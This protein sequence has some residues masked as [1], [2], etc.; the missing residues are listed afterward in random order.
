M[1]HAYAPAATLGFPQWPAPSAVA[2]E[3]SL[4]TGTVLPKCQHSSRQDVWLTRARH[5]CRTCELFLGVNC[6]TAVC[7]LIMQPWLAYTAKLYALENR[8]HGGQP[9]Q[10]CYCCKIQ[11]GPPRRRG[12]GCREANPQAE[13]RY[14]TGSSPRTPFRLILLRCA[15][16]CIAVTGVPSADRC[17]ICF[18]LRMQMCLKAFTSV[19]LVVINVA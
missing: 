3:A 7:G 18:C 14:I 13:A 16:S 5:C 4:L 1:L 11:Q 17:V 15:T 8:R 2:A 10:S 9:A 19:L 6:S 12:T